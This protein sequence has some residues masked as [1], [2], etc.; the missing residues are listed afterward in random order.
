VE[1]RSAHGAV[2]TAK[3]LDA[4]ADLYAFMLY[5]MGVTP[6]YSAIP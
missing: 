4:T 3:R 1:T 5:N 2:S 6:K